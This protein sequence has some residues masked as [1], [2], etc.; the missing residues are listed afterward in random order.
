[1]QSNFPKIPFILSV[2]FF[3]ISF[4]VLLYFFRETNSNVNKSQLAETELYAETAKRSE[5]QILNNSINKIESERVNLETHFAKSSD[6]VP[7]LDTI[8]ALA[9]KVGAKAEVSSVDIP[10]DSAGLM[11]GLK[12]SGSFSSLYKFLTLM[13]N[14]SY[15]L[16]IVSINLRKEEGEKISLWSA[17]FKIKLLSFT[18]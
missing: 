18:Q 7:F 16:E 12:A 15:E 10:K 6:V 5:V 8:E 3:L 1:M 9:S 11:V 2:S 17:L 13:E 4:A 14:S